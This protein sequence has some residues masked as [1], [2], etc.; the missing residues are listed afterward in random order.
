MNPLHEHLSQDGFRLRGTQM[1]RIDGFSDVVFGFA[2]TLLV[3]SLEVPKSFA[4]LHALLRGFAPF[5]LTFLMLLLLWFTHYKFFRRYGLHDIGTVWL[6]GLLLFVLLFYIYPLKFMFNALFAVGVQL[7]SYAQVREMT[8][9]YAIGFSAM[10]G[11]V[12]LMYANA[13]RRK[14][15]LELTPME[16]ELTRIYLW[17]EAWN[18]A[19]GL[20]ALVLALLLPAPRSPMATF[21]FLLIAVQKTYFGRRT[22]GVCRKHSCPYDRTRLDI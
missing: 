1:S 18:A 16:I 4:E 5:S 6:N 14:K 19:I 17:E 2:L 13:L 12:A 20:L 9:L 22:A 21:A 7:D 8:V 3:V 11:L 10:Y 15:A